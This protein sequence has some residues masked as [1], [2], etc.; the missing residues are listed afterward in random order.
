MVSGVGATNVIF[1]NCDASRVP[2]APTRSESKRE[3]AVAPTLHGPV[4]VPLER[5]VEEGKVG[6]DFNRHSDNIVFPNLEKG[7]GGDGRERVEKC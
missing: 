4:N 7:E 3:A 6:L 1:A 2:G 5:R